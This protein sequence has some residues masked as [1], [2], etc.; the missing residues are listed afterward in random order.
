M[1]IWVTD[2]NNRVPVRAEAEILVGSVKMDLVKYS[3]LQHPVAL[4]AR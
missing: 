4:L 1:T 2:D 3:G